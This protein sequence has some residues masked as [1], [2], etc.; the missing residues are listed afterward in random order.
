VQKN[1]PWLEE[2]EKG[3]ALLGDQDGRRVGGKEKGGK[4]V[5]LN[6]HIKRRRKSRAHPGKKEEGSQA[7]K[8]KKEGEKKA[9]GLHVLRF[10][11]RPSPKS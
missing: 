8:K 1:I 5:E 2:R 4:I 10:R 6:R 7:L 9:R 3:R 11:S